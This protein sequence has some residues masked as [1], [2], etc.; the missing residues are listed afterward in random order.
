MKDNRKTELKVGVTVF[1][2]L[3]TMIIIFGWAKNISL[4]SSQ[5]V[6]DIEFK[7]VAGLEDGDNVTVN[8]VRSGFV[9]SI[10]VYNEK[11]LVKISLNKN[12]NLKSNAKFSVSMIDLMG[13]KKI[14]VF[15]GTTEEELDLSKV[16]IGEFYADIPTVMATIGSLGDDIPLLVKQ[17]NSSLE[18]IQIFLKDEKFSNEL[19]STL[20]NLSTLT[21]KLNKLI[22]VNN[23][24]IKRLADNS[25]ELTEEAKKMLAENRENLKLSVE[26]II[27]L[28]AK[29]DTL[30]TNLNSLVEET[31]AQKNNAGRILYDEALINNL[32]ETLK[33]TK[34]LTKILLEQLKGEGINIDA[35]INLF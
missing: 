6:I 33:T 31:K 7:N 13:G 10:T 15:P 35:K 16:Q 3:L 12:I 17:V 20:S 29:S 9:E 18:S 32:S 2:S 30:V 4:T 24:N 19:K 22:D 34:E 27:N 26:A 14:E 5:Q 1:L 25:V 21:F 11:V 28:T 23:E 8:G